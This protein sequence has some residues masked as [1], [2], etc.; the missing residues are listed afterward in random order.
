M[1]AAVMVRERRGFDAVAMNVRGA[2]GEVCVRGSL[3]LA[4]PAC[5]VSCCRWCDGH[6]L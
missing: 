1:R 2:R 3:R 6:A 5:A 4:L